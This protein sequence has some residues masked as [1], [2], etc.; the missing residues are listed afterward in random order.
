MTRLRIVAAIALLASLPTLAEAGKDARYG[1]P[2]AKLEAWLSR[3]EKAYPDTIAGHDAKDLIL[4]DGSRLALSDGR[5]DK[6]FD[7]LLDQPD[8]DDM[9]AFDYPVGAP[10]TEPGLNVD[11]GRI[12]V[13]A[14][15][16][17][18]YG[19]CRKGEVAPRM[20]KVAWVGG[21]SV[22]ITTAQGADK[23]LEAVSKDLDALDPSFKKYLVPTA[24]TYNCRAIAK[25]NRMSM[26]AYGAAIDINTKFTAY[27]QWTKPAADGTY[28]FKNQIP[29]EIVATFERHGYIWGGRWYHYD[30]MHFE[31][32]PELIA[33]GR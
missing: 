29:P 14:L 26:H 30:T 15:F 24:G 22:T 31:Y 12:R 25:T 5:S 21:S 23:A 3:L 4:K 32:R 17:A 28:P 10:A 6:D 16:R 13:E 27:W 9:F 11:P 20:R 19:D 1:A 33:G 2:P 7:T 18:L 8:I